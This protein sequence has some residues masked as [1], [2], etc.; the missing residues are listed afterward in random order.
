[1]TA[2]RDIISINNSYDEIK[3]VGIEYQKKTVESILAFS[4]VVY[5]LKDKCDNDEVEHDFVSLAEE[6]WGLSSSGASQFAKTGKNAEKLIAYA[7][8]LPP[9]SRTLY[10]LTQLSISD[11]DKHINVG[12]INPNSTV[13]DIKAIKDTLKEAKSSKKNKS[14]EDSDDNPFNVEASDADGN[15]IDAELVDDKESDEP[16]KKAPKMSIVE[17]LA[18]FDIDM[19]L[20]YMEQ[21]QAG[22]DKEQL[23][24]AFLVITGE[25]L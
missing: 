6:Y 4:R 2:L 1:M 22:K 19:N 21:L 13:N 14:K 17:A 12:D 24:A 5:T 7:P 20:V 16:K 3:A 11:L 15:I 10:E 18:V 25:K 9:S 8:S 23:D